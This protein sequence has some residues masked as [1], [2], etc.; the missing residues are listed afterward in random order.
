MTTPIK[1]REWIRQWVNGNGST[2]W[3][4]GIMAY[5]DFREDSVHPIARAR[6]GE[7]ESIRVCGRC[8]EC[9]NLPQ[10]GHSLTCSQTFHVSDPVSPCGE[11]LG[12]GRVKREP[13]GLWEDC[14]PCAE[15]RKL[16]RAC[17]VK[18]AAH[19]APA[20]PLKR[21]EHQAVVIGPD[22]EPAPTS[23]PGEDNRDPNHPTYRNERDAAREELERV[24]VENARLTGELA[25]AMRMGKQL[26]ESSGGLLLSAHTKLTKSERDCEYACN[27]RD[28]LKRQLEG[29]EA[30]WAKANALVSELQAENQR[31]EKEAASWESACSVAMAH[32]DKLATETER[33]V[34]EL[35][36]QLESLGGYEFA[37]AEARLMYE[38][39]EAVIGIG[40]EEGS[41]TPAQALRAM[42]GKVSELR[43]ELAK[44][45]AVVEAAR[46]YAAA[47]PVE[48]DQP[49]GK[50]RRLREAISAPD[51]PPQPA[52]PIVV[53]GRWRSN[54]TGTEWLV[55]PCPIDGFALDDGDSSITGV[56]EQTLRANFTHVSDPPVSEGE[57]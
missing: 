27:Q 17:G 11:C 25:E 37:K 31:L 24:R 47:G 49:F 32:T 18:T 22:R 46:D 14:K 2:D 28:E 38:M 9:G 41:V 50:R 26:A 3:I 16:A 45:E 55:V 6:M 40:A 56:S 52:Q 12:S 19:P 39:R 29:A 1:P 42:H 23:S 7:S 35:R 44:R 43:G 57:G 21:Y 36:A 13:L 5:L 54:V 30:E 4:G 15:M 51:Q 48:S 33:L 8:S 10:D 20:S 34:S 53:G